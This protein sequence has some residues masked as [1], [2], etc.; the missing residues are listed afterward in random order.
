LFGLDKQILPKYQTSTFFLFSSSVAGRTE[1]IPSLR[2]YL[3]VSS[4]TSENIP[5]KM[6]MDN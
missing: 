4:N 3:S 6:E 5:N 2:Q 1:D